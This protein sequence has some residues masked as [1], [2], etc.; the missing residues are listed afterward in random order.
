MR[1]HEPRRKRRVTEIDH[2]RAAGDRQVAAGIGD[3]VALDN[4]DAVRDERLCFA[5]KESS[6]FQDG[7]VVRASA[8]KAMV[9][10]RTR[11]AQPIMTRCDQEKTD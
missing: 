7:D 9:S 2:L 8:A 4:D 1:V 11:K 10:D 5:I 6:G 3:G